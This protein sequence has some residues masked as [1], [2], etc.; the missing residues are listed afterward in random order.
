MLIREDTEILP[1][2]VSNFTLEY[3]GENGFRKI[4]SQRMIQSHLHYNQLPLDI[5]KKRCKIIYTLRDPR[6]IAIS[7][8]KFFGSRKMF[9]MKCNWDE[10]LS[11]FLKGEGEWNLA[12]HEKDVVCSLLM[13]P[14][15][16][17]PDMCDMLFTSIIIPLHLC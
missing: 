15:V 3:R 4:K 13:C 7:Y 2:D 1:T 11:L 6:D 12:L 10:F 5:I 9:M 16:Q 17:S 8:Y 14:H